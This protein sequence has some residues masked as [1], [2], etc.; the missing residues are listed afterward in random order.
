M[1][2]CCTD[3]IINKYE[4]T[5]STI[6]LDLG[7]KEL[8]TTSDGEVIENPKHLAKLEKKLKRE[9]R[10]LSKK[11]KKSKNRNKQRIKLNRIHEKIANQRTDFLQKVSTRLIKENQI[12]CLEDL[13]VKNMIKN[14]KL[15]KSISDVSWSEFV[16]MLEY[17]ALWHDRTIQK[18]DRFY[19]SSQICNTCG[20]KNTET[21]DLS[22]R[23]W[24]CPECHTIHDRDIN[25]AKNL[26]KLAM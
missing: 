24:E 10:R 9:Q 13:A 16:R 19:A 26:L 23:Q 1:S 6:G 22:V 11:Q 4:Q 21:K 7:I 25:A 18:V 20:Y 14:H 5:E 2:I 3:V 15:A 8:A 12:I 17:K